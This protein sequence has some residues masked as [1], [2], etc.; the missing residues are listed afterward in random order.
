MEVYVFDCWLCP[1]FDSLGMLQMDEEALTATHALERQ[2]KTAL[3][4]LSTIYMVTCLPSHPLCPPHTFVFGKQ[5]MLD[6]S[7]FDKAD[8]DN[9][10]FELLF[11]VFGQC[12]MCP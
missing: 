3:K 6:F 10:F 4:Q 11:N 1:W 2:G 5:I 12:C 7:D 8:E 9:E